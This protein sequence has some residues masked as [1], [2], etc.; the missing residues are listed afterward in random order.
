MD[1][2]KEILIRRNNNVNN[3]NNVNTSNDKKYALDRSKFTPNT[4][5]AQLAEK[6]ASSFNDL[7]NYA[8]YLNVVKKL[9]SSQ[10]YSYWKN[11][12]EEIEEKKNNPRYQIRDPKKYFAWKFKRGLY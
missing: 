4:E 8:F 9:G 5:E 6:I 11:I 10:T 2:P 1:S 7:Q 12:K 3:D